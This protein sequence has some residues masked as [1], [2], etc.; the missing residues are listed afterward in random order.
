[1]RITAFLLSFFLVSAAGC[2][3]GGGN[4]RP[5]PDRMLPV[6][7]APTTPESETQRRR[8][9]RVNGLTVNEA[10]IDGYLASIQGPVDYPDGHQTLLRWKRPP[11]VKYFPS[12]PE[13]SPV[14]VEYLRFA[15]AELNDAL[16]SGMEVR[17]GGA[18]EFSPATLSEGEL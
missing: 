15:V 16:P 5:A 4:V 2:G 14:A 1:M 7:S 3:G 9:A 18:F 17:W 13:H 10:F 8:F 6:T 11:M 12:L